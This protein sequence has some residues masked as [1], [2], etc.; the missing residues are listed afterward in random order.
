MHIV[1]IVSVDLVELLHR[2]GLLARGLGLG[3]DRLEIGQHHPAELG[4]MGV[5]ALAV[6]ERPAKLMLELLDGAG[7]RRLADVAALRRARE[8]ELARERDEIADL[9]HLHRAASAGCTRA[10]ITRCGNES[11]ASFAVRTCAAPNNLRAS[12]R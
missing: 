5:A 1:P 7:Q 10:I 12:T 11:A 4:Q 3:V 2:L 9:L 8:I 6:E